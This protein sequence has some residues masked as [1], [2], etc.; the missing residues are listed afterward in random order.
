MTDLYKSLVEKGEYYEP[1]PRKKP[2]LCSLTS[3]PFVR[4]KARGR[5]F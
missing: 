2:N 5:L 3:A 4:V 1:N